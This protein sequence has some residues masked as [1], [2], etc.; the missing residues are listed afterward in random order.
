MPS[1]VTVCN[2]SSVL[3][4]RPEGVA[5]RYW[6][7]VEAHETRL[8][9]AV[10]RSDRSAVVGAGKEL[11]ESVAGLVC[12]TLAQTVSTADDFGK[13][14]LSA[15]EAL[16]RRPGRG[17]ATE[18]S[19]RSIAQ[20]ARTILTQLNSLRNEVGTGHGRPLVPVVTGETATIA[21]HAARLW[22]S[23]ALA[24]L[25]EVLRGEVAGLV[26]ELE[27]GTW[28]RGKLAERFEEVGLHSLHSEDQHR[29]GVA[30]AHR[31]NSLT[32]VV[33]E[34][35]VER[36]RRGPD[37]WPPSYR[38]GVLLVQDAWTFPWR[39]L[40]VASIYADRSLSMRAG[41]EGRK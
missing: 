15:H 6:E 37:V 29:L 36:I 19:V 18:A 35:G 12:A 17:A 31:S 5:D 27:S 26:S 40:N 2:H 30:V 24:R 25:D 20:A 7:A 21:E 39:T 3:L 9:D 11:C 4:R 14:I 13:L 33:A 16:D 23:W 41:A 10:K 22:A 32:F 38:A 1:R 34:T 8:V 28:R